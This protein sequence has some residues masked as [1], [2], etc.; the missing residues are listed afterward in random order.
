MSSTALKTTPTGEPLAQADGGRPCDFLTEPAL[1]GPGEWQPR[2]SLIQ[3]STVDWAL[4]RPSPFA[5]SAPP[6]I[7]AA[8]P[9][10]PQPPTPD[11][12]PPTP[13]TRHPPPDTRHPSCEKEIPRE[14]LPDGVLT[15]HDLIRI[16]CPVVPT[17]AQEL[18]LCPLPP[19]SVP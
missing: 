2:R 4:A 13:D 1:G 18:A 6:G 16:L 19:K 12:Q 15:R 8:M 14:N 7:A 3:R 11:P 9:P 5:P 17:P 10:N